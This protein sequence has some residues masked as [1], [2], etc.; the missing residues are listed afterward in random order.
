M[1][2]HSTP[3]TP[4]NDAIA[5]LPPFPRL[6]LD[7]IT[8]VQT[9][10]EARAAWQV[11]QQHPA[12]GFDTESKPTFFKD[13]ASD[14][15]HVLQLA[16]TTHAWVIQLHDPACRAEVAQWLANPAHLKAGFGLRDDKRHL[17]RK[18]NVE[19]AGVVELNA[20]F[21]QRGYRREIGVKAAVAVLFGQCFFKSKK[22]A[23]SN[24]SVPRLSESQLL[25]AANDA[26]AAACLYQALTTDP[27]QPPHP[28]TP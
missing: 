4:D 3:H 13:Q 23:T 14:G 9:A 8:L 22:T 24:W 2:P 17:L 15:P 27:T 20:L 26:F 12:W 16:T 5:L 19:P 11:L 6:E 18:L 21:R 7:G 25:Y 10:E 1:P 28:A